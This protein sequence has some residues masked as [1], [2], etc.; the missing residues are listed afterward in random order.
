M[1]DV[2]STLRAAGM[3]SDLNVAILLS[4]PFLVLLDS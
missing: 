2:S 4:V 3:Q 1:Y